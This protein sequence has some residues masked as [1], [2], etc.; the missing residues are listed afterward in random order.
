MEMSIFATL[1]NVKCYAEE[2]RFGGIIFT[3]FEYLHQII[4]NRYLN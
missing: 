3:P 4:K 1:T 2:G